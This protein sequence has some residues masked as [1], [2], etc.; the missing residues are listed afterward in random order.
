MKMLLVIGFWFLVGSALMAQSVKPLAKREEAW[1]VHPRVWHVKNPPAEFSATIRNFADGI[2]VLKTGG[3]TADVSVNIGDLSEDD[4]TYVKSAD[5]SL[6][7][8][9]NDAKFKVTKVDAVGFYAQSETTGKTAFIC[10]D[11]GQLTEGAVYSAPVFWCGEWKTNS[12]QIMMFTTSFEQA[13]QILMRRAGRDI[14]ATE[15][16]QKPAQ[17][18][19]AEPMAIGFISAT[20]TLVGM[21]NGRLFQVMEPSD[22]VVLNWKVGQKLQVVTPDGNRSELVNSSVG[23]LA[24]WVRE[25]FTK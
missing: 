3:A 16:K 6:R 7:N 8:S 1:V 20:G 18:V 5:L 4:Q 22:K 13:V 17:A 14:R 2:V 25:L 21:N 15:G 23:E 24:E 9:H 19:V 11:G 12:G 10:G